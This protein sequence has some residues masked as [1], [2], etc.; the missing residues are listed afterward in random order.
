MPHN[1][2]TKN[3]NKF[4]PNYLH[5]KVFDLNISNYKEDGWLKNSVWS[6]FRSHY[7][8]KHKFKKIDDFFLSKPSGI[9]KGQK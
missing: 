9:Y 5:Y 8:K 1:L 6:S 4:N 3:S 7:P 2:N